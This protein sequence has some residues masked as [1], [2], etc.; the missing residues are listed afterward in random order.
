MLKI[1]IKNKILV[2]IVIKNYSGKSS[3]YKPLLTYKKVE[4]NYKKI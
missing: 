1:N 3:K 2:K 4:K